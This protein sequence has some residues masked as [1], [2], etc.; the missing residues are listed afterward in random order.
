MVRLFSEAAAGGGRPVQLGVE[1]ADG[2]DPEQAGAAGL[3]AGEGRLVVIVGPAGAGKTRAMRAAVRAL[4]AQGRVVLGLA[5][6]AVAAE[7]LAQETGTRAETVQRFLV[8]H[9]LAPQPS[10]GLDLPVGATLIVDEAG[11]LGTGD[12]ERLMGLARERGWRVALVGDSRQL[13]AVGRRDV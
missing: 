1:L 13:A 6:W 8:E 4:S 2:L 3:V 12:A 11:L 10:R 5:P 7:Q 9:E